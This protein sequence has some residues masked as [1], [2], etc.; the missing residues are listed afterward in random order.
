MRRNIYDILNEKK[1]DLA[2]EYAR[3][4]DLFYRKNLKTIIGDAT[5]FQLSSKFFCYLNKKLI[6]RCLSMDDFNCTY[7]FRFERHPN[8]FD[9]D[10]LISFS[11]YI[12]FLN[13]YDV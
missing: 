7:G 1:I 12:H 2:D 10:N 13:Y 8:N 11:I 9:I 6:G 4:Y 3:I 5:V